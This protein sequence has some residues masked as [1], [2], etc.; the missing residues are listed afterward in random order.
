[1]SLLKVNSPRGCGLYGAVEDTGLQPLNRIAP[2]QMAPL[3]KARKAEESVLVLTVEHRMSATRCV[4][5]CCL[6]AQQGFAYDVRLRNISSVS[7]LDQPNFCV[8]RAWS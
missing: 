5:R 3:R 7:I 1:M 2:T 6:I 8:R 4:H